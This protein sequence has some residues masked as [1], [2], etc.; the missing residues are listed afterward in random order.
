MGLEAAQNAPQPFHPRP[1]GEGG[2]ETVARS[3]ERIP[4]RYVRAGPTGMGESGDGA[5]VHMSTSSE[6]PDES[7]GTVKFYLPG[8]FTRRDGDGVR[9][10]RSAVKSGQ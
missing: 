5:A 3:Q 7:I 6:Y 2:R 4:T 9:G 1:L 8:L 10:S